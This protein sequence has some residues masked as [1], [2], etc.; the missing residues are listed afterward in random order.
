MTGRLLTARTVADLLDVSPATV[1]RWTR[2]G[3]LPAVRL[4]GGAVRYPEDEFRGWLSERATPGRGASTT[5]PGAASTR[6]VS[7]SSTTTDDEE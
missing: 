1:L 7:L 4:P 2:Q 6:L 3:Q 5:T